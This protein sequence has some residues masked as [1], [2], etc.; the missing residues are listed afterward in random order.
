MPAKKRPTK[1]T[2]I[3]LEKEQG[4]GKGQLAERL[5]RLFATVHPAG[6]RPFSN[7]Q[8]AEGIN[9]RAGRS[10]LSSVYLWQLRSGERTNPST[11]VLEAIADWFG[12][13]AAYF[14]DPETAARTDAQ[15]RI[16]ASLSSPAVQ[17]LVLAAYGLSDRA[18]RGITE[19]TR[20]ARE[21][22]GLPV[23]PAIE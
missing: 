6:A 1:A 5:D 16:A 17:E 7:P 14:S 21:L 18:I 9:A 20:S 22:E 15:L 13:D 19:I 10:V 3:P 4:P 23:D 8:A 12:V 11:E 2:P